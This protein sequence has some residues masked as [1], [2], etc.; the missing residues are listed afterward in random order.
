MAYV[1]K[2][3]ERR[4]DGIER[5][6][7]LYPDAALRVFHSLV[8]SDFDEK[9]G[10]FGLNLTKDMIPTLDKK[11]DFIGVSYWQKHEKSITEVAQYIQQHTGIDPERLY[12][13]EVGAP[14][15]VPGRQYDKLMA[16][17]PEAFS[18][19]YAFA[20]TWMWKQ[21]WYDFFANGKPKNFG[22]WKW[23]GTEGKVEWLDEPNSGLAA[24]HEL[25]AEW[26][27]G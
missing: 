15:K 27:R 24:I 16:V 7:A 26:R 3:T 11:P 8:V 13:D 6:R 2:I 1:K 4:Q 19:G 25:N 10:Y 5:A 9:P 14:E 18:V 12:I 17:V 22:M 21:T 23:A 20:C